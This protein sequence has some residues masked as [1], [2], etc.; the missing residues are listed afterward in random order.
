MGIKMCP[1][2][3]GREI[4]NP[5]FTTVFAKKHD[6]CSRFQHLCNLTS[7]FPLQI[8]YL[9]SPQYRS[10]IAFIDFF[11]LINSSHFHHPYWYWFTIPHPPL[12]KIYVEH[13]QGY[14]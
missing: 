7:Y 8:S 4:I 6:K 13:Q 12:D 3:I 14:I 1:T 9:V 11:A 2:S 5:K 10:Q